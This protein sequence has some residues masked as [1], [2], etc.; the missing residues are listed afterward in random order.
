MTVGV[1]ELKNGLSR[2]LGRTKKGEEIVVTERGKPVALLKSIQSVDPS[3]TLE[4]R[5]ARA[6]A[7]G[8]IVLPTRKRLARIRKVKVRGAL[9]SRAI[10]E[11][12]R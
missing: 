3:D 9:I 7:E 4:A 5:L 8:L 1:R 12:R 2:Y 6:A 11:D 10:I